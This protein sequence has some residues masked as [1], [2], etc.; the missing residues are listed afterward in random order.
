MIIRLFNFID[1]LNVN[2]NINCTG[3]DLHYVC[4]VILWKRILQL[5]NLIRAPTHY[6]GFSPIGL[7]H[8]L[9]K[10]V[11]HQENRFK[12]AECAL[13][14]MDGDFPVCLQILLYVCKFQIQ[15]KKN[16]SLILG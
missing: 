7:V 12:S 14:W 8:S 3:S 10:T 15:T 11:S 2:L 4:I 16:A 1:Q 5:S 13:W 9:I 6:C